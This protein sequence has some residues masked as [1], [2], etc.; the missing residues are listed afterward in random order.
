[1]AIL[2]A[3]VVANPLSDKDSSKDEPKGHF[4]GLVLLGEPDEHGEHNLFKRH[5]AIFGAHA[6]AEK[7][8]GKHQKE[9]RE[10]RLKQERSTRDAPADKDHGK[11]ERKTRETSEPND[12][13]K[14]RI[15]RDA[16]K[17]QDPKYAED[18]DPKQQP[19]KPVAK[20]A[21][22]D[23]DDE[24]DNDRV[25]GGE[26]KL[27]TRATDDKKDKKPEKKSKREAKES[28]PDPK[29]AKKTPPQKSSQKKS[30][31]GSSSTKGKQ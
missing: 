27:Q 19:S 28:K 21:V 10:E 3:F 25:E 9:A 20:R 2:V 7:E 26:H 23:D 13:K 5:D 15:A 11:E 4:T 18:T 30:N 14:D 31:S 12:S 1:M 22:S 16:P 8:I 6:Y 29:D 17:E 24:G